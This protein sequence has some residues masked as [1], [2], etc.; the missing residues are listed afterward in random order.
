MPPC[1][2]CAIQLPVVEKVQ[3]GMVITCS[4]CQVPLEI[5][6]NQPIVLKPIELLLLPEGVKGDWAD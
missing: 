3:V 4:D 5:T 2:V 6:S 1:P